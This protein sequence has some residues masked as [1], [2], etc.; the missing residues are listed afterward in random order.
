M[1]IRLEGLTPLQVEICDR[2]WG[3]ESQEEVL[4][5]FN[6]LPRSLQVTAHAMLNLIVAEL[7]DQEIS[8]KS[9]LSDVRELLEQYR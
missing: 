5:W 3:M 8:K 6:A 4:E 7:I 1:T 9:D 2:I